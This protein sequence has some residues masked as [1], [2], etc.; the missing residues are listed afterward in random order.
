[1]SQIS[2][3]VTLRVIFEDNQALP[4]MQILGVQSGLQ[5]L[6][7][8]IHQSTHVQDENQDAALHQCTGRTFQVTLKTRDVVQTLETVNFFKQKH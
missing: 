2:S 8:E 4:L 3:M 6:L 7:L 5:G 1:M